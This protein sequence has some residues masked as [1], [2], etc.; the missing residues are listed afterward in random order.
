MLRFH[1]NSDFV[2]IDLAHVETSPLPSYGDVY[3]T[4]RISSAGF[5]G[6]NDLWVRGQEFDAFCTALTHLEATR[7]GEA[8]LTAYDERELTLIVRSIDAW[9]HMIVEG[10]T[11]YHVMMGLS[12]KFHCVHFGIEFDPSQL[13]AAKTD[14]KRSLLARHSE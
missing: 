9:G 3:L 14:L 11:G 13:I 7:Q 5:T 4:V 8:R 1:H 6:H 2:E 10:H 12:H